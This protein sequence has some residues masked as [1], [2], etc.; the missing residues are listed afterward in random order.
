MKRLPLF[1]TLIVT[2]AVL[3]MIGLGIWQLQRKAQKEA[4]LAQYDIAA[5]LPPIAYPTTPVKDELPLFRLSSVQ[6][7]K[8]TDWQSV[9]GK[10]ASGE[11]GWAHL[12][13]CQTGGAEGPGATVAVGWSQRPDNPKWD[14]GIINGMIAPDNQ[15]L[16][17]LVASD[18]VE[19]LQVLAAPSPDS[20][21]NNHFLYAIQW[22]L[23]AAAAAVIYL[24]AV[25]KRFLDLDKE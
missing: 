5:D 12:A 16:I 19:G 20:I 21:P 10:S 9:S 8:I 14:G 4:V 7:I 6:C 17:K 11:A 15:H 24:L 1:A 2:L 25:R 22:F 3:I 18:P 23:F 13:S